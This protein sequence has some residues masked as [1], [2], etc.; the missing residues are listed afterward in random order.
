M[1]I[2]L[3]DS[4][5]NR[6]MNMEAPRVS[7]IIPVYGVEPYIEACVRSVMAQDYQ[8]KLEC[9]LI[10]DCSPDKSIDIATK[11]VAGYSGSI[12]FRIIHHKYNKGLSG[13]RNTGIN[14]STGE[15]CY[16]LD[17]DD[18]LT[19]DCI[20][21]LAMPAAKHRVDM[22]IGEYEVRGSTKIFKHLKLN[23]G[24]YEG[25]KTLVKAYYEYKWPQ[26]A[27]AKLYNLEFLKSHNLFFEEGIIHE[28][29]LWSGEI[30]CLLHSIQV[31]NK[32][33]YIYKVRQ[34]S[35]TTANDY[36]R[37]MLAYVRIL[38]SFINFLKNN[39]LSKDYDSLQLVNRFV[40]QFF[41][42][43]KED[44]PSY[45]KDCYLLVRGL[46]DVPS[47]Y[48]FTL[49]NGLRQAILQSHYLLPPAIGY[50]LYDLYDRFYHL[51]KSRPKVLGR[52]KSNGTN[53]G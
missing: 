17:S 49:S 15:Y 18:E 7:L 20:S 8:G 25:H 23:D 29:E 32:P 53:V 21:S 31:V 50:Y 4:S 22:V 43:T 46:I 30:A 52:H 37:K 36:D 9:L 1:V 16:F 5:P 6:R 2:R 47:R 28:D 10:D 12:E 33:T 14:E 3:Q 11:L 45:C 40:Y 19:P 27:V 48:L 44:K 13:A 34:G 41:S 42:I 39:G 38:P 51:K 24:L 35:I 26:I